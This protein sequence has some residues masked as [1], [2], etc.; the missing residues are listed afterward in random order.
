MRDYMR[1]LMLEKDDDEVE[2][3]D[4]SNRNTRVMNTLN[5]SMMST[6]IQ[7]QNPKEHNYA[8]VNDIQLKANYRVKKNT[9]IEQGVM[10]FDQ[11]VAGI[12]HLAIKLEKDS[13]SRTFT[14][15]SQPYM[16]GGRS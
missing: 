16:S 13:P 3:I 10:D 1:N 11:E 7:S 9:S 8:R 12:S 4:S 14:A 2:V 5:E 6:A 15:M